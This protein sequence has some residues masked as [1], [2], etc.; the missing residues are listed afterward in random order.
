MGARNPD[1]VLIVEMRATVPTVGDMLGRGWT[2]VSKC[3]K[4]ELQL[5]VDLAAVARYMGP[6][7]SLWCAKRHCKKLGC[8]GWATYWAKMP[9]KGYFEEL[10]APWPEGAPARPKRG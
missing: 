3:R 8:N 9:A 2:V 1:R 4:C 7:T 6:Q 10:D 5:I